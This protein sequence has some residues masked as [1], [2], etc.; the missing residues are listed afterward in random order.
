MQSIDTNAAEIPQALMWVKDAPLFIDSNNLA[1]LYDAVVRP[2]YKE[3]APVTLKVSESQKK[4]LEKKFGG[5]A[6]LHVP[7]W[8]SVIL[9]GGVDDAGGMQQI[10]DHLLA[11]GHRHLLIHSMEERSVAFYRWRSCNRRHLRHSHTRNGGCG[12]DH[13]SG[14]R[15]DVGEHRGMSLPTASSIVQNAYVVRNL[16]EACARFHRLTT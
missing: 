16:D 8:L 5:K 10:F 4:D 12:P 7:G 14:P 3:D 13:G 2:A 9:S 15:V 6:G 11:H 1:Q